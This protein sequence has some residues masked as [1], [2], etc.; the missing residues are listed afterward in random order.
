MK[1]TVELRALVAAL[2]DISH[3]KHEVLNKDEKGNLV[4]TSHEYREYVR[5]ECRCDKMT[6]STLSDSGQDG[7]LCTV[8]IQAAVAE[9]GNAC[10]RL[11]PLS[12]LLKCYKRPV[13][14]EIASH[15]SDVQ[16]RVGTSVLH[17]ETRDLGDL[18]SSAI[19]SPS[20]EY[21]YV[22][23]HDLELITAAA[24]KSPA[25]KQGD[26][27]DKFVHVSASQFK[28]PRVLFTN[29]ASA[30]VLTGGVVS[31]HDVFVRVP[32]A[33]C[34]RLVACDW[35]VASISDG[36]VLTDNGYDFRWNPTPATLDAKGFLKNILSLFDRPSDEIFCGNCADIHNAAR[37]LKAFTNK[38][39][40][41]R[42]FS[43][44]LGIRILRWEPYGGNETCAAEVV[45][46]GSSVA[47]EPVT[48][49]LKLLVSCL[50]QS[51]E[52][53]LYKNDSLQLLK[54]SVDGNPLSTVVMPCSCDFN[55]KDGIV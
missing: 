3:G 11:A 52:V 47:F 32:V 29:N 50:P 12:K 38:G 35:E 36:R 30:S 39:H 18:F 4:S 10:I 13:D 28:C 45:V 2:S 1:T 48:V 23:K 26:G 27:F 15:K 14:I 33:V 6:L 51:G 46:E 37:A 19:K 24:A 25:F 40:E 54:M 7:V 31:L 49:D 53:R 44:P 42:I 20:T 22:S 41:V 8:H 34:K 5:I 21:C 55:D 43:H 16:A 17:L 9:D